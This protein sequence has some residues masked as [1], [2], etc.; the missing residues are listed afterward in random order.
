MAWKEY[1]NDLVARRHV[2]LVNWPGPVTQI[3][4][5]TEEKLEQISE[6]LSDGTI[7]WEHVP[8]EEWVDEPP[9]KRRKRNGT[10]NE[11]ASSDVLIKGGEGTSMEEV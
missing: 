9:R 8:E 6:R 1:E 11:V 5:L 2:R 3:D 7:Q 10:G 4:N